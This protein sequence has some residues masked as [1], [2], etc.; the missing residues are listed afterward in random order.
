M[1]KYGFREFI[2]NIY[3]NIFIAVQLA[4]AFLIATAAVSSLLSRT[5]LYTPVK[6]Y[7]SDCKGLYICDVLDAAKLD[8]ELKHIGGID[9]VIGGYNTSLY[10]SPTSQDLSDGLGNDRKSVNALSNDYINSYSPEMKSGKWL[11]QAKTESGKIPAVITENDIYKT[12]DIVTVMHKQT[13]RKMLPDEENYD[14]YDPYEYEYVKNEVEIIGVVADKSQL[15]GFSGSDFISEQSRQND[16]PDFRDLYTTVNRNENIMMIV[17]K[18]SIESTGCKIYSYGNLIIRLK[19]STSEERI[20]EL[21][22][23][24]R[25]YG[26]TF[27]LDDFKENSMVYINGQLIKL[28]PMLICIIILVI[29]SSVSASALTVK[30]RLKDYGIYYI[31]GSKWNSCVFIGLIGNLFT[32]VMAGGIAVCISNV[33]TLKGIYENTVIGF[34]KLHLLCCSCICIFNIIISLIIPI[35]IMKRNTP[36]EI[37]ISTE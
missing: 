17:P 2:R 1:I 11:S 16:L 22:F 14:S 24:L 37:L 30:K 7:F 21:E 25:D 23:Y 10:F 31:C 15:F 35:I 26:R 5:E 34:G 27:M 20:T 19:D 32:A 6:K 3:S 8:A 12:G 33:L 13:A 28:V 18:A 36:K 4:I 29:V 9:A